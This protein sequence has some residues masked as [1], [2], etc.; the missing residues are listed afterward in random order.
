MN[1]LFLFK[2]THTFTGPHSTSTL[3]LINIYPILPVRISLITQGN[4]LPYWLSASRGR[5]AYCTYYVIPSLLTQYSNSSLPIQSAA[6]SPGFTAV[7]LSVVHLHIVDPEGAVSE[8]LESRV[9]EE[10]KEGEILV[11]H[12]CHLP[13]VDGFTLEKVCVFGNRPLA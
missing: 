2:G 10:K 1:K 11:S 7:N 4:N 6:Y 9:L 12:K 5:T 3:Y 8:Q 13:G